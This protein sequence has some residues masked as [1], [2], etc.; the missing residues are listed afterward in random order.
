MKMLTLGPRQGG[1][2][3]PPRQVRKGDVRTG[4]LRGSGTRGL[5]VL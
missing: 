3:T 4:V 5:P 1:A 2:P